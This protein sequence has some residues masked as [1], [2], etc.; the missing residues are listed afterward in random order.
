MMKDYVMNSPIGSIIIFIESNDRIAKIEFKTK[1]ISPHVL[2][3]TSPI[4]RELTEYFSG[5]RRKFDLLFTA[6]GTAFDKL[7]WKETL[8]IPYGEVRTYKE[9]ASRIGKPDASR[10]VGGALKRNPIPILIPCHRVVA[11]KGIGGY[12]PGLN[13]KIKLLEL[14]RVRMT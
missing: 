14:E 12:T 9:I 13:Y 2:A 3:E 11:S 5:R 4:Y 1:T 7:V 8:N 10:A 6:E